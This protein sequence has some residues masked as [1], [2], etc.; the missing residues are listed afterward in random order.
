[1]LRVLIGIICILLHRPKKLTLKMS[2]RI[3]L[4]KMSSRIHPF[5]KKM[6]TIIHFPLNCTIPNKKSRNSTSWKQ[7]CMPV[8]LCTLDA[9]LCTCFKITRT[10]TLI[11]LLVFIK[12][13]NSYTHKI[14]LW[15]NELSWSLKYLRFSI[16]ILEI[17]KV[18]CNLCQ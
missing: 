14:V 18:E 2:T 3:H 8:V 9:I 17:I 5:W 12:K 7:G 11:A 4:L 16:N 10:L 1:M 6:S 15:V 13:N